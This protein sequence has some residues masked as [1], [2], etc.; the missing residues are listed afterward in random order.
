MAR[1][2]VGGDGDFSSS[3]VF[4]QMKKKGK[5]GVCERKGGVVV[6]APELKRG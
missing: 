4:L 1:W 3:L 6:L 2:G 5:G